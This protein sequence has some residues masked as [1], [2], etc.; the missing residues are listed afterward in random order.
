MSDGTYLMNVYARR[1]HKCNA[2]DVY[3][4]SAYM[5][6][7]LR[8][9]LLTMVAAPGPTTEEERA[10][11]LAEFDGAVTELI[12]QV[13]TNWKADYVRLSPE[14]CIDELDARDDDKKLYGE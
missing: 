13:L 5:I 4:D 11:L 14:D 6:K 10:N 12:E 8:E 9:Q 7:S 3:E 1:I 2:Q